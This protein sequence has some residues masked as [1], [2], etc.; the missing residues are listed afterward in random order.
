MTVVSLRKMRCA[1]EATEEPIAT[2][3]A[4]IEPAA[5]AGGRP[6]LF[7]GDSAAE[8][9]LAIIAT[10]I[11]RACNAYHLPRERTDRL[12]TFRLDLN[13]R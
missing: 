7:A 12:R 2:S 9:T 1:G 4:T 10:V 5:S 3:S 6:P 13:R 11:A 8:A